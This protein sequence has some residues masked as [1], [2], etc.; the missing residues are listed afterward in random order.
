MLI[1]KVWVCAIDVSISENFIFETV[2]L[3]A[4][5]ALQNF[6]L[7]PYIVCQVHHFHR[8]IPG[9]KIYEL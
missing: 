2:R 1:Q 6:S 7:S 8:F 4:M 3:K 5:D 9:N